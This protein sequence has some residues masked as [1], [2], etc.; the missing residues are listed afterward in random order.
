M[1]SLYGPFLELLSMGGKILDAGCGSGRDTKVFA[2]RG[3][4]V[5]AIDASEKMVEVTTQLSGKLA[6][7][8][9]LQEIDFQNEFDG[10]WACASLLHVPRHEI[11]GVLEK[12]I[13][14]LRPRGIFYMSFKEG[15]GERA[16][17]DRRF[18]DFTA[19]GLEACIAG[20]SNLDIV[21]IWITDDVRPGRTERWVNALVRKET[22]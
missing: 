14:S 11:D 21:R 1:E 16:Q 9:L 17:G 12:I 13:C 18:T 10:V 2:E 19:S 3:Y 22:D 20:H 15:D 7:Q 8:L 4:E 6:R 5:T